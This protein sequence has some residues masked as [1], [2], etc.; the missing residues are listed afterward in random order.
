MA[1]DVDEVGL[2]IFGDGFYTALH[3][4]D[5]EARLIVFHIRFLSDV[6]EVVVDERLHFRSTVEWTALFRRIFR[7]ND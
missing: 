1:F 2:Q 7:P 5:S 6:L 4:D 3:G